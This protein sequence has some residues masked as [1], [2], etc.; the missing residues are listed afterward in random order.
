MSVCAKD[1]SK[2]PLP[3][4]YQENADLLG[5][6][7]SNRNRSEET[8]ALDLSDTQ[9][10]GEF[11][12]SSGQKVLFTNWYKNEPDN[13]NKNQHYVTMW[14][15]GQWND[16]PGDFITTIICQLDCKESKLVSN[17]E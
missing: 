7:I 4:A 6:F 2:P 13:E 1:H 16:F 10:E 9:K 14:D 11:I 3:K 15:D 12:D 8:F 17:Y 5:F